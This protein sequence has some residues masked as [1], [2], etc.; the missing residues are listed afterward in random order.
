MKRG[1]TAKSQFAYL[2]IVLVIDVISTGELSKKNETN[3]TLKT[4]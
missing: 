2:S 1:A 4:D 3:K